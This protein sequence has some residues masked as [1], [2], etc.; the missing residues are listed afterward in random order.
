VEG[1]HSL[2]VGDNSVW[3]FKEGGEKGALRDGEYLFMRYYSVQFNHSKRRK[4]VGEL[5]YE[6][7]TKN[8]FGFRAFLILDQLIAY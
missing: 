2:R 7:T 8:R 4:G 5:D 6:Q 3:P 1:R